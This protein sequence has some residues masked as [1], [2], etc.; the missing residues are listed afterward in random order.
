[1]GDCEGESELLLHFGNLSVSDEIDHT[2]MDPSQVE[3]IVQR[4]VM[5]ALSAQSALVEQR[6]QEMNERFDQAT[7]INISS[8][9]SYQPV[10]IN[11]QVKCEDGLEVIKSIVEFSGIRDRYVSWRQ[12]ASNAYQQFE[13]FVG[14]VKHYQAVNIIR[15][16]VVGAA[17]AT[18]TGHNTPLN[19]KAIIA[20]L[21]SSYGDK[22]PLY[23]LEQQLSVLRQGVLSVNEYYDEVEKGLTK[24]TNK[25]IMTYD[26]NLATALNVKYRQDALR[27]FISGLKKSLSDVLF[28]SQPKDMPSALALAEELEGNRERYNFAANFS[29]YA[30]S[31]QKRNVFPNNVIRP[32]IPN[33]N[34]QPNGGAIPK[35]V[36]QL[37]RPEPMDI[38]PSMSRLRY[39]NN[40][41]INNE[42]GANKRPNSTMER[43]S[44]RRRQRVNNLEAE[45][46]YE[47]YYQQ[48]LED[49][50]VV[51]GDEVLETE[52][53]NFLVE[54]PCSHSSEG[55]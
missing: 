21:D 50:G 47:Q 31:D 22:T 24:L 26:T 3:Q 5:G 44:D 54:A 53:V 6:F 4:A 27:V 34:N 39:N 15:N 51:D 33:N 12:S 55:Q 8:V 36:P 16:K 43:Q 35:F 49:S 40:N 29:R 11:R 2:T 42:N 25:S 52:D 13:P 19:F 32:H 37:S 41:N 18:L 45:L 23:L 10:S 48:V 7:R 30:D 17:D 9:E 1:M 20:R 14:S 28:A 38:D 46:A